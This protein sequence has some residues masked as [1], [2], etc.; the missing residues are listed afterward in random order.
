MNCFGAGHVRAGVAWVFDRYVTDRG[1]Y[2]LQDEARGA[3]GLWGDR[4]PVAP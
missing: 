1:P 2:A 4:E 3:R